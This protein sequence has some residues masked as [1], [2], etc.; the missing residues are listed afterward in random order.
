MAVV[1]PP[2]NEV[3]DA[4][5]AP[6]FGEKTLA[7]SDHCGACGDGGNRRRFDWLSAM[8]E[9]TA[10]FLCSTPYTGWY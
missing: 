1:L 2:I 10:G 9:C 7:P 4:F 6:R 5:D 8:V 3:I